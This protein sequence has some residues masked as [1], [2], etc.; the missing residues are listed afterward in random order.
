MYA[1]LEHTV[2]QHAV[3]SLL[4]ISYARDA[5]HGYMHCIYGS[6]SQTKTQGLRIV[7]QTT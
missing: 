7:S 3:W 6:Q 5:E 2:C 4:S 1:F